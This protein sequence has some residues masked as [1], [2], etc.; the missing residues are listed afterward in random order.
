MGPEH[1]TE[2]ERVP[3]L[4]LLWQLPLLSVLGVAVA[5]GAA[6]GVAMRVAVM[7]TAGIGLLTN[8]CDRVVAAC[9]G[10]GCRDQR[11]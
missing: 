8:G 5:V 1:R 3:I 11:L 7:V 10:S 6:V 2:P 4:V 9:R